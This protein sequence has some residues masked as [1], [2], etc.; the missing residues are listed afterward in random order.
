M[1]VGEGP[2]VPVLTSGDVLAGRGPSRYVA[3]GVQGVRLRIGDVVVPA[4]AST[5]T[6]LVVEQSCDALL[7][8]GLRLLRPDPEQLNPRF[9]AGVL[10]SG[11]T[12]RAATTTSGSYRVDVRRVELARLPMAEQRSLGEA[13]HALDLLNAAVDDTAEVGRRLVRTVT[14]ALVD[15]R[16]EPVERTR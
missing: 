2:G 9:L 6:A 5:P 3:P 10:R 1:E 11:E 12:T 8:P 15:G 4:V 7:G 13:L 16:L 14:D